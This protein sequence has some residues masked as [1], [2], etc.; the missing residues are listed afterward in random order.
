MTARAAALSA[1]AAALSARARRL[2]AELQEFVEDV[3]R[4]PVPAQDRPRPAAQQ[5]KRKPRWMGPVDSVIRRERQEVWSMRSRLATE[6]GVDPRPVYFG[7]MHNVH[8]CLISRWLTAQVRSIGP[9]S[10]QDVNVRRMINED[11]V[12]FKAKSHGR[13]QIANSAPRF[14]ATMTT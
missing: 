2:I 14:P 1:R 13:V 10:T 11:V 9:G 7:V 8:P 4:E 3:E 5:A 12:K 6:A